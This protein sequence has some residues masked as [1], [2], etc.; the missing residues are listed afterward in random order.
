MRKSV[1]GEN[2]IFNRDELLVGALMYLLFTL[3]FISFSLMVF[4]FTFLSREAVFL[5]YI[6]LI[7]AF[8]F[9]LVRRISMKLWKMLF[10]FFIISA[11]PL[12]T[13]LFR[14]FGETV[15]LY[16]LTL[17]L[18]T[19]SLSARYRHSDSIVV[20]MDQFGASMF[21]HSAVLLISSLSPYGKEIQYYLL[22]HTL[23]SICVF[24]LARQHF[25]FETAYGHIANSPTQ[26]S[27][28]V[29]SHHNRVILFLSTFALFILPVVIYFPYDVLSDFLRK[30]IRWT[31][32]G[33]LF[34]FELLNKLH[35]F[36]EADATERIPLSTEMDTDPSANPILRAIIEVVLN[37]LSV[38]VVV[39][40]LYFSIRGV[41]RFI[42]TMYRRSLSKNDPTGDGLVIDEV[43]S[44]LKKNRKVHKKQD[45]GEGEAKE[46]R[47]KYYRSVRRAMRSGAII[48]PSDSPGEIRS[49]VSGQIG[50][51]FETLSLR[52]AKY[53]Y[54]T[55]SSSVNLSEKDD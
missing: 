51:D 4:S 22:A 27:S 23:L 37:V 5:P 45:F 14:P 46:I 17:I 34:L 39:L 49:A 54:G 36:P 38:V 13:A 6:L 16:G 47:K 52:Y 1:Q 12:I 26:P 21:I 25:V 50:T 33:V 19:I 42:V 28:I 31:I 24:F 20:G 10:L 48:R 32:S 11:F 53:R 15:Y 8:L 41:Y 40:F 2:I 9:F 30:I 7:P 35:L 18:S 43:F 29:R 3:T 55:G 44:I